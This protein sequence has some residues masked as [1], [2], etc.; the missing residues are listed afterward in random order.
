MDDAM[1]ERLAERVHVGWMLEKQRQ[2][3]ADHAFNTEPG[4]YGLAIQCEVCGE[5]GSEK[6]HPDMLPYA[7]LAE[8]VKAYDR[9]TVHAV[10]DALESEGLR[11]VTS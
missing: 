5:N 4:G 7:E 3:Y 10:L 1:L 6:H 11:I 9:A 8:H 2:G